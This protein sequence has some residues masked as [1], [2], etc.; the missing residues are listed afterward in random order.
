[1]QGTGHIVHLLDDIDHQWIKTFIRFGPE[2]VSVVLDSRPR[3]LLRY[4]DILEINLGK[5]TKALLEDARA[6]SS[7]H[8]FFFSISSLD[9]KTFHFG[10]MDDCDRQK[11]IFD[12]MDC[13]G[14]CT[15]ASLSGIKNQIK[16]LGTEQTFKIGLLESGDIGKPGTA[17]CWEQIPSLSGNTMPR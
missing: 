10:T 1:M 17:V 6:S 14:A 7:S 13:I 9:D 3:V 11:I 16:S 15:I 2:E 5:A 8:K 4:S 12:L